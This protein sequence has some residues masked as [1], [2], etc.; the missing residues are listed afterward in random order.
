MPG[1]YLLP[2]ATVSRTALNQE[3][4]ASAA[5]RVNRL[6]PA[7]D[8]PNSV[9]SSA[10]A[11]RQDTARRCLAGRLTTSNGTINLIRTAANFET[12]DSESRV[13][14]EVEDHVR[15]P[16]RC[17]ACALHVQQMIM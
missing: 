5:P 13:P 14:P 8:L 10:R 17:K 2:R 6:F 16:V 9:C 11:S 7:R 3:S 4:E 1:R 15:C 12:L